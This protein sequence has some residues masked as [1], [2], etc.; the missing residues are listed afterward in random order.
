VTRADFE[1]TLRPYRIVFGPGRL[2][3]VGPEV[4]RLG[5]S[6]ALVLAS[7]ALAA[8][9]DRVESALGPLSAGRFDGAAMHTPVDVTEQALALLRSASADCVVAVGGGSTTGLAKAL[10]V[11]TD[12]DQVILPTTYAGSEVTPVLGE[13][14]N[15]VKTTRTS[16]SILPETVIYDVELS[17]A[18]PLPIAVTSAVNALA[19]AVEA[20]YSPQANP[21]TDAWALDAIGCIARGLRQVTKESGNLGGR[22]D[23]LR[24][25]WLSG[26]CLGSVGMGLHHKLCHVLGGTFGLP[27]AETHTVVL[28]HVM[29]YNAPAVPDTM[30]RIAAALQSDDAAA[31]VFELIKASGG[32]T[33]LR[34]LGLRREDLDS[35]ARQ[36]MKTPY[37]NPVPAEHD[38]LV[39]LL[40][41]AWAGANPAAGEAGPEQAGG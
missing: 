2:E 4:A 10:A 23:L 22:S 36:A 31:G 7:P 33:A 14:Q 16:P 8:A 17:R 21:V 40:A 37:P 29:A 27:H 13:T 1:V 28:A 30:R 11:R 26:T 5:R 20:L 38:G 24:G 34:D 25:A 32:P 35:A 39:G 19:H 15:A 18:L 3:Q 41:D 6:R 9:G 12:V